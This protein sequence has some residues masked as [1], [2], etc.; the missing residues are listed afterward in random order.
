MSF[1]RDN[2]K[3]KTF[4]IPLIKLKRVIYYPFCFIMYIQGLM[5]MFMKKVIII[6]NISFVFFSYMDNQI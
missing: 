4:Y 5:P 6:I 2:R 3:K 1:I